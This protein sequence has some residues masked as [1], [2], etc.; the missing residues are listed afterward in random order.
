MH[1]THVLFRHT[2]VDAPQAV[3]FVDVHWTHEL[4]EQMSPGPQSAVLVQATQS[5]LKHAAVH[6]MPM[7]VQRPP[8]HVCGWSGS[9]GSQRMPELQLPQVATPPE[10]THMYG[11]QLVVSVH[12]RMLQV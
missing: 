8:M 7:S 9:S 1:A 11:S 3:V 4:F 5:P 6:A 10:R 2:G 12:F